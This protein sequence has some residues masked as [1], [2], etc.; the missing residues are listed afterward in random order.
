MHTIQLLSYLLFCAHGGARPHG[1]PYR[2][3]GTPEYPGPNYNP[4]PGS[5]DG[6][7]RILLLKW[8]RKLKKIPPQLQPKL[9]N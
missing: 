6:N 1:G 7:R 3:D 5:P 4:Q 9:R 2:G 8:R